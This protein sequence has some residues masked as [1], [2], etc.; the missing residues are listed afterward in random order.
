MAAVARGRKMKIKVESLLSAE[1][2]VEMKE[3][4]KVADLLKIIK[5]MWGD[6]D[7][8]FCLYHSSAKMQS[9][10]PLFEYNIRDGSVVK[11]AL[12]VESP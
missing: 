9:D 1:F 4:Q 2:Y 5:R 3:T 7:D 10:K 12:F 8:Y 11:V 6:K